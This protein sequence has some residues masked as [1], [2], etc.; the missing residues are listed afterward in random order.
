MVTAKVQILLSHG[1]SLS[2]E[3]IWCY[4]YSWM[5]LLLLWE[6]LLEEFLNFRNKVHLKSKF[7]WWL[8]L[9]TESILLTIIRTWD[10]SSESVQLVVSK[11]QIM[12]FNSLSMNMVKVLQ[13][14]LRLII[15]NFKRD[16][17]QLTKTLDLSWRQ[18][19]PKFLKLRK[20]SPLK[21]KNK[22]RNFQKM[23][24]RITKTMIRE[25]QMNEL[26]NENS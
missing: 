22:K 16:L 1:H 17:T 20:K 9:L 26:S 19:H 10:I 12:V 23:R 18:H 2:L 25:N 24:N 14:K 11:N 13:R 15:N 5:F 8:I 4:W 6:I 7:L 21:S 3:L